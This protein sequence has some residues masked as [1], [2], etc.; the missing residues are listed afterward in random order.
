VDFNIQIFAGIILACFFG[1]AVQRGRLFMNPS[2]P[3]SGRPA[4]VSPGIVALIVL[5][6]VGAFVAWKVLPRGR[7]PE[8]PPD[9]RATA[10]KLDGRQL[11]TNYCSACHGDKGEGDGPAARFLYPKPRDFGEAKF[12]LATTENHIPTDA[13][14][15]NVI[16]HGMP[17]SAMFPF[18]HLSEDDRRTLVAEIR[19]LICS[20]TEAR[21]VR[22]SKASGNPIDAAELPELVKEL[23]QVNASITVPAEL[24]A[25]GPESTARGK[26]LY[27]AVGCINCHGET[28]KGDGG[29]DQRDD[30]GM[31]TKPR[32]FTRGIF[33]GG[34]DPARLF[35]LIRLGMR[36]TPMPASRQLE[37]AQI[38][39]LV[40]YILSFSDP[41]AQSRVEHK[42]TKIKAV[43][44]GTLPDGPISEETWQ[45]AKAVPI[46]I[47]PL[48]W[49]NYIEPELQVAAVHDGKSLA[50]RMTW[51]DAT[52]DDK[53]VR[54][55]DFEDMAA[56]Q[57]FKGSPEPFLGMG[58]ANQ[59]ID[60]WLWRARWQ[61][62]ADVESVYPNMAVDMYPFE[63]PGAGP[64]PHAA[65]NQPSEFLTAKA[66]GN[67]TAD[68]A[69]D[70]EGSNLQAKG[71]GTLT[72]RP[73]L[74]QAVKSVGEWKDGRWTVVLR[75]SLQVQD[76]SGIELAPGEKLSIGFAV[77]DGSAGDR[78]GQKLVSIWHDLELE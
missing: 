49:R 61:S 45:S 47:S 21:L 9:R 66:A 63:K 12:R 43:K 34:R 51:R 55:Q 44:V 1:N 46:V 17:G 77:W 26:E 52:R 20:A 70:V 37:P 13:D 22:D 28:G 53:P 78:N 58:A 48:W 62:N 6:G 30:N 7:E 3:C 16:D 75:R 67:L 74:S 14:L 42:R 72:M 35:A 27:K 57:L 50:I 60:V 23:T 19:K 73:R 10:E 4:R 2:S 8:E 5:A 11:Y 68:T 38:G 36:G 29:Q 25:S 41:A 31:P 65:A 59:P 15:M 76:G 69:G 54:P 24:P 18:G 56:V 40:N 71:F 39:D 33:K 32:D 64:D